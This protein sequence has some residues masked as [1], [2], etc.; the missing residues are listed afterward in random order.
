MRI[1]GAMLVALMLSI[2]GTAQSKN[3]I[4][5][6]LREMLAGRE[7]NT[8]AAFEQMPADKFDYKPTPDQMTFAHLAAHIVE[9]NYYF[10]AN[11]GGI[12]Q[13]KIEE[14]HGTEGKQKLVDAVKSSFDFCHEALAKADDSKMT[15]NIVWFDGKQRPRAWAFMG[16]ASSWADHYGMA[17]TYLRLNGQTPPTG[18]KDKK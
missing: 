13:P 2:T 18:R 3:P 10:C 16:L 11:V 6:V 8:V 5:D 15:D 12:P 4:S 17:A 7:R 9:S 1:S 14:L